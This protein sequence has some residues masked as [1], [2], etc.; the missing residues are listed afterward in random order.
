MKIAINLS[1]LLFLKLIN[2]FLFISLIILKNSIFI[3]IKLIDQKLNKKNDVLIGNT[4][5]IFNYLLVKSSKT[6][7]LAFSCYSNFLWVK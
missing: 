1:F 3:I 4:L 5:D 6:I 7:V 2:N